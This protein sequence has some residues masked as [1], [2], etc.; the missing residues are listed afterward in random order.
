MPEYIQEF[1]LSDAV[2][3][4]DRG[5]LQFTLRVDSRRSLGTNM[6]LQREY[7]LTNRLH[8]NFETPYG[9]T[10]GRNS[11]LA[12]SLSRANLGFQYQIMRSDTPFAL[13]AGMAFGIQVKPNS[14]AEYEPRFWQLRHSA[15]CK[16]MPA[17]LRTSAMQRC[18]VVARSASLV[19][20]T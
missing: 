16:F 9:V 12:S 5:E 6:M 4:E 14:Q 3:N 10:A 15:S 20:H 11:E 1:F 7:G 19:S 2:R 8:L 13:S 18:V 17:S